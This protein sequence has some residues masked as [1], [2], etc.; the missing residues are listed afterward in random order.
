VFCISESDCKEGKIDILDLLAK[1]GLT[2]SRSEARRA[3]IQG[4]V[5]VDGTKVEDPLQTYPMEFFDGEG[6]VI[7]KGKK[8]FKKFVTGS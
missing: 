6:I 3:V 4:G 1:S 7:R 5:T 8:T 2:T